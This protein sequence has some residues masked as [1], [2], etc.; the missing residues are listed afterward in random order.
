MY[1]QESKLKHLLIVG[2][3]GS[4]MAD[5]I[6]HFLDAGTMTLNLFRNFPHHLRIY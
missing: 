6:Q 3:T 1:Y 4:A 2:L 5:E